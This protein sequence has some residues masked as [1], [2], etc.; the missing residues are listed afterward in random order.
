MRIHTADNGRSTHIL[1]CDILPFIQFG[2]SRYCVA[3]TK[4][5][6]FIRVFFVWRSIFETVRTVFAAAGGEESSPQKTEIAD[7]SR[8]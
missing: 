5:T 2:F 1:V 6:L 7:P 8:R 4:N 3:K